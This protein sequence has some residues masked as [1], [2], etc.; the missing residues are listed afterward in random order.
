MATVTTPTPCCDGLA[1]GETGLARAQ[2]HAE[3]L[4]RRDDLFP[5]ILPA[6]AAALGGSRSLVLT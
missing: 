5:D 2:V 4:A 1:T 3:E 6:I